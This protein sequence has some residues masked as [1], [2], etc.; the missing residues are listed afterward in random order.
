MKRMKRSSFLSA[1]LALMALGACDTK[2]PLSYGDVNSIIA[3]MPLAQWDVMSQDVYDALEQRTATARGEKSFTVTYQEPYAQY[4][5]R[6]R[7]F[8]QLLVVG[9]R[10]DEVVQEVLDEAGSAISENGM[11]QVGDVWATGQNITLILLDEGWGPDDLAPYLPRISDLLDGQFRQYARNR[12][13]ISGI[14]SAL[15]D[16]LSLQAGFTMF[17]PNVY[18]WEVQDSV[19]IFRNDNPDPAELIRQV[20]V[21]WMTPAPGLLD[22]EA[23]LEWR[24]RLTAENYTQDQAID[25][26]ARAERSFTFEGS[27]AY[28][29][30]A[31]WRNPPELRWPAGGP[32][33]T[34]TVTCNAQDRTYL[35]D[36]W[37]FAPGKEKYEYMIQLETLLDTFRCVS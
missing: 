2:S 8:R 29:L 35:L 12:M 18:R 31:E 26:G 7:R 3:V 32:F 22:E 23:V 27:D 6:L 16:T 21:T 24:S 13:F 5:D 10:S 34:R 11:H 17:F 33:I 28:E 14:D 30:Q 20:A 25:L 1:T 9:S 36:A 37:L 19:Y 4:W 15:A